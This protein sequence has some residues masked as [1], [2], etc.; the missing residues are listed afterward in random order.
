MHLVRD[1]VCMLCLV[2]ATPTPD[3]ED[4]VE[5]SQ[6]DHPDEDAGD[7]V[8]VH[9][10]VPPLPP[11]TGL[12]TCPLVWGIIFQVNNNTK[13]NRMVKTIRIKLQ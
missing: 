1:I 10:E 12:V 2:S 9:K 13:T 7:E 5:E 11:G 6:Q 8:R 4:E 3:E